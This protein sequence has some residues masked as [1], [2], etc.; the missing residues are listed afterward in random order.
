[1]AEYVRNW[2]PFVLLL[3]DV[4][5]DFWTEEISNAFP[6]Y[7]KNVSELLDVC[8]EEQIDIVHLR[9]KFRRDKSDWMA[10]YKILDRIPCIEGTRGAE[11]FPFAKDVPGEKVIT[12]QTFDGFHNPQLQIHLLEN[13]KR[14]ILVAGLVT[15]VCLLLTA[16]NAAQRG[17]LVAMVEDC[18]ADKPE[19][20]RHTLERY[21]FIFCRTKVD[22]ISSSRERWMADLA[23]L[24]RG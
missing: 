2:D 19:A 22:Q 18:C 7:E 17:Y 14:F 4:Q 12:K 9:A 5:K 10:T 1:M 21:P 13:K 6:D 23:R 16:A 11:I 20:H 24:A 8:R 3:I 15:S